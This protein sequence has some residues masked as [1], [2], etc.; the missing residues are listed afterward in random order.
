[1]RVRGWFVGI[2]EFQDAA[3]PSLSGA[4]RDAMALHAIF[5]DGI[6][7]VE[8]TLLLNDQ[9]SHA[10]IR[11]S[12]ADAFENADEDDAIVFSLATHGTHDYRIVAHDTDVHSLDATAI[13]LDHIVALFRSSKAKFILCIIDCCFSGEA[14][15]RV[16]KDTPTS[17]SIVDI[18][19]ISGEGRLLIAACRPDEVAYEHP[20]IRHGLLTAA[21]IDVL[22]DEHSAGVLSMVERVI[23]KVRTDAAS[24]GITQN[25]VATTYVDG[26]FRL[27]TL[28]RGTEYVKAFPEYGSIN[29][30]KVADLLQFGIPGE[31]VAAWSEN[32][33]N[34]LHQIQLDA[35]NQRRV[36]D[37]KSLFVVAPTSSGKTFIGELAAIKAIIDKKRAVFLLP[38]KAL[39]NEKYDDFK[40][41]YGDR[42]GMRVIRCT[43]DH[44]DEIAQF[45]TG[46]FDI[47][48]LTYEMFLSTA[49]TNERLLNVLGLVV[50]DE[51]QFIS[52]ASRGI[53]VELIL[54]LLRAK[55]SVGINPQLVLLSAV[56]GNV[57]QFADWLSLDTLISST[58]PVPLTFGAIDRGGT[59]EFVD[60]NGV[61]ATEQILKPWEIVQRRDKPSAQDVIVPLARKLLQADKSSVIVFRNTRGGAQG[62]AGYLSR[63]LRLDSASEAVAVLPRADLS[64]ASPDLASALQ[65]GTAFHTSDLNREERATVERAFRRGTIRV[66]A[67]TSGIAAGINTPASAV[68][69]AETNWAGPGRP[70]M[71]IGDVLNMAGRAGRYGYQET[72]KAVI[73]ADSAWRR[74]ALVDQY[75]LGTPPPLRSTFESSHVA[76]WLIRLLRQIHRIPRSEV[77]SLLLNSFGG[78]VASLHDAQF[79]ANIGGSI[80][81]LLQRMQQEGLIDEGDSGLALTALGNACGQANI[82]LESCISILA[83]VRMLNRALSPEQLMA[84]THTIPESDGYVPL[85]KKGTSE[86]KWPYEAARRFGNDIVAHFQNG[87][88]ESTTILARA[89]K[90]LIVLSYASGVPIERIESHFT[91]NRYYFAVTAGDITGAADNTRFRLR[92]VYEIVSVAYPE[93]A[94]DPDDMEP[95]LLQIELGIPADALDLINL[96][97]SLNRAGYLSLRAAGILTVD[98]LLASD[99]ETLVGV[100]PSETVK[101]LL[102][103]LQ[104]RD[105]GS[106]AS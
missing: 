103:F 14:P 41:L 71:S 60:E 72:G 53:N 97:I 99:S 26:G 100:L 35:V 90:A 67:A 20:T 46:K 40:S 80:T 73:I 21:L 86:N 19:G 48:I 31:I 56:V 32:F 51:A 57:Q 39:V 82:S 92:T 16:I 49:L 7:T 10:R 83:S 62:C 5:K 89:K 13:S 104:S 91:T 23:A 22:T 45:V 101:S 24:I 33:A 12:L 70:A 43:G 28:V 88:A 59:Y 84:L 69:I 6:P 50:L 98:A 64:S 85:Q 4:A 106:A 11:E 66:I 1:M 96:P 74:T 30:A 54:T 79:L 3:A 17:R 25:P 37:G 93:F 87:A 58:R 52:D 29:V 81:A 38:F 75:V 78:Y 47:A 15:A 34:H 65:G 63:E 18:A 61:R 105:Q 68:I 102:P 36:L 77:P 76:T 8:A 95:F 55:R 42:L 27:P 94:P 2:D 44:H 9:A